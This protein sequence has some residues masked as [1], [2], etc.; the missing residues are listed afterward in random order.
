MKTTIFYVRVAASILISPLAASVC[1]PAQQ[2]IGAPVTNVDSQ[3]ADSIVL[4][5]KFVDKTREWRKD[6]YR[7]QLVR[8]D[9]ST[10]VFWV[11]YADDQ[12]SAIPGGG[13]SFEVH[14]DTVNRR[15]IDEYHFQ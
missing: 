9:G 3:V 15:V 11:I 12:K 8:R 13:K 10:L 1:A 5:E 2:E 14:V 4:V 7:I 6:S